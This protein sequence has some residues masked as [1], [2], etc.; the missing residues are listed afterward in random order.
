MTAV[1]GRERA[2]V[3]LRDVAVSHD[4]TAVFAV[5]ALVSEAMHGGR[6]NHPTA[7]R[8]E[9]KDIL[10]DLYMR[11]LVVERQAELAL[12]FYAIDQGWRR[13]NPFPHPGA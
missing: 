8:Q 1:P 4:G 3:Y 11:K 12:V 5:D 13:Q 10:R 7:A 2:L 6:A 9:A